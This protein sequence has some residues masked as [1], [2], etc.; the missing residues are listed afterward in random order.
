[1]TLHLDRAFDP[2]IPVELENLKGKA[3]KYEK[4]V[5]ALGREFTRQ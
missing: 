1:M 2:Q 3:S 5:Q 4:L